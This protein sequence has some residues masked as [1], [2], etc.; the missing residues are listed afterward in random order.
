MSQ[1]SFGHWQAVALLWNRIGAP[2][3]PCPED[4]ALMRECVLRYAAKGR[5]ALDGL[6]LGVTPEIASQEWGCRMRLVAVDHVYAMVAGIWPGNTPWRSAICA[7][8]LRLPLRAAAFDL[9]LA[10]GSLTTQPFPAGYGKLAAAL[11]TC[12]KPEGIFIAR[13]F[14]RPAETESV[15]NVFTL[16]RQGRIRSFHA[17]KWRLAMAVQGDN[18]GRGACLADIWEAY[19]RRIADH[20]DL[21]AE[22]GWPREEI[23]TIDT[24]RD[25]RVCYSFPS[26][27]ET[28]AAMSEHFTCVERREGHYELA[29]RCPTLAFTRRSTLK[30]PV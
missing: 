7:D 5:D 4:A 16:L 24:Y 13:A 14:C 27:D 2:L 8:W 12:L 1:N 23:A 6:P 18:P 21:V 30:C 20:V 25:S 19:R 28:V 26:E 11:S 22:T 29:E 17:F 9:A 10:D 3:R 15:E